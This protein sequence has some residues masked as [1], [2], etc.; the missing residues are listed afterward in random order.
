MFYSEGGETL[1]EVACG[2]TASQGPQHTESALGS[3]GEQGRPNFLLCANS[4]LNFLQRYP[5]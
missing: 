2:L 1:E 5:Q 4:G 3:D